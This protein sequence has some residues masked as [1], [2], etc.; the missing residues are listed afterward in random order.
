MTIAFYADAQPIW[1]TQHHIQNA[2][3]NIDPPKSVQRD[4][5]RYLPLS[6]D[7]YQDPNNQVPLEQSGFSLVDRTLVRPG[8]RGYKTAL[9]RD[10]RNPKKFVYVFAGTDDK[11][12][13]IIANV[14]QGTGFYSR[15]YDEALADAKF[16]VKKYGEG[17]VHFV[18]HSLG[19][20]LA[21][22]AALSTN[23][24]ATTFNASGL[25][26][27]SAV[28]GGYSLT[29][30]KRFINAIRM[31]GDALSTIQDSK[32]T[33]SGPRMPDGNGR[34][35]WIRNPNYNTPLFS[36]I[37]AHSASYILKHLPW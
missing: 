2:L 13:D 22:H 3:S 31:T 10:E 26:R 18:G 27:N 21:A 28:R 25:H 37:E 17:N 33:I 35:Y 30:T 36:T 4:V 23:E 14:A 29:N 11:V 1:N 19:G 34:Y 16:F 15:Q 24:R 12:G 9:Y 5:K 8:V 32:G 7:V 20:G 6:V